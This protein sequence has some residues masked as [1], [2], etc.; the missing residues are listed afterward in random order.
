MG[1][2]KYYGPKINK[3]KD[4]RERI[5]WIFNLTHF[6]HVETHILWSSISTV[7]HDTVY[8][9][10]EVYFIFFLVYKENRALKTILCLKDTQVFSIVA[11][12]IWGHVH[13][14][15]EKIRRKTIK[16]QNVTKQYYYYYVRSFRPTSSLLRHCIVSEK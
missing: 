15:Y 13:L 8:V 16:N 2:R 12:F 4:E 6:W 10:C 3:K 7:W 5:E 1:N 9:C 14:F 11:I